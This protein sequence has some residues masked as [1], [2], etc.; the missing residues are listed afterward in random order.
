MQMIKVHELQMGDE[1]VMSLHSNLRYIRIESPVRLTG[2]TNYLGDPRCKMV[3]CSFCQVK[4]NN[5]GW[6]RTIDEYNPENHNVTKHFDLN[7]RDLWLVKR[8]GQKL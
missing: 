5:N 6:T 8:D 7:A 4:K 2:T 3:R 1:V